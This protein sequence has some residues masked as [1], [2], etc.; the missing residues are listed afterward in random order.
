[1]T[2][3][4]SNTTII[5]SCFVFRVPGNDDVYKVELGEIAGKL[6]PIRPVVCIRLD[7]SFASD[8]TRRLHWT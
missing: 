3:K 4:V 5:G 7:Q 6:H 1:M 2:Q 8:V